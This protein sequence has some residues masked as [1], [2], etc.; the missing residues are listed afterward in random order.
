M[1]ALNIEECLTAALAQKYLASFHLF[2]LD[3]GSTDDTNAIIR[4]MVAKTDR[5][6]LLRG[7]E[8]PEGWTGKNFACWQLANAAAQ[9]GAFDYL[10]FIDADV[11]LG[12]G[13]VAKSINALRKNSWKF[14][15]PYPRQIAR[16]WSEWLIQPLLQWSWITTLPTTNRRAIT[17]TRAHCSQRSILH[18]RTRCLLLGRWS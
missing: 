2:A 12:D 3:D 9:T 8:L 13:A 1:S 10:V 17:E 18:P 15:S 7:Q 11:R 14:I 6:T 4:S 5:L 16:S